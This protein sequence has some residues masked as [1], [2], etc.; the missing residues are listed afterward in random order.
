MSPSSPNV[1]PSGTDERLPLRGFTV[2]E[3]GHSVAAP[4]AGEILGDLGADVIKVEKREGGDDARKWAP[5]FWHGMGATFQSLNRNKRSVVVD[6]RDPEQNA[7]LKQFIHEK[8]DVVLQNLRPGLVAELGLDGPTL[9]REKPELIYCTIG[10]FGAAGPFKN[11][12]GYDPLMQAFAGLMSVTGEQGRPPVRVGV[13]IIDM[14]AGMW[15]VIGILSALV[16]RGASREGAIIDTS[17]YETALAWMGHHSANYQASGEIPHREGSGTAHIVPYRAYATK[18]GF[19]VIAA[20]NDKLF[21]ALAKVLG[22]PEWSDDPRF[23]TNPDRVEHKQVL[24]GLI[25]K[26]VAERTTEELG[27]ALD[28]V[29]VPNAP[30]QSVDQ[31]LDHE[32]TKALGI[33]LDSPDGKIRL[34]GSPLSIDGARLPFRRS[35]PELGAHTEEVLGAF[36]TA[37]AQR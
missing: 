32:Q 27:A 19:I 20:G 1:S 13:S 34:I 37:E 23:R 8:V 9:R 21:G 35:T 33:L 2:V 16:R 28:P 22:H 4:F 36:G 10:A 26:L 17:L 3:L 18:N 24:Y 14:A 15:S 12:P 25:E 6:L 29:R 5:P 30:I 7:R 11:R 31:V